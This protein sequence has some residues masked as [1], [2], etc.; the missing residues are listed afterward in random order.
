[1]TG[2]RLG[3]IRVS[4]TDQNPDRQLEN[5]Q[6]DKRFVEFAS[7]RSTDRPQ[8]K[9]ILDYAREDDIIF[10][11]SMD[12][13]ARNLFDLKKIIHHLNE[14]NVS[15]HFYKE[16]LIFSGDDSS[17]SKL[18]LHI[19]GAVAE[20]ELAFIAERQ[21]EGIAI[22]KAKGRY[23]G[24]KKKLTQDQEE[25]IKKIL[26]TTRKKIT[27]IAREFN[28]SRGLIHLIKNNMEKEQQ[29]VR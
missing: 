28:V 10:V 8:L 18:I 2:K 14:K 21:R 4:T 3:Y 11:H 13:L 15:I 20:F 27:D 29:T 25:Q 7:S 12:R 17:M 19:V 23:K 5:V 9:S 1:M 16:N 26:T 22:A 24:R 6:L